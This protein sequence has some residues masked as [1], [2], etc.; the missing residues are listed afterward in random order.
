MKNAKSAAN[1]LRSLWVGVAMTIGIAV[2]E[3]ANPTQYDIAFS[4]GSGAP[5]GSFF[6]DVDVPS[7]SDFIVTWNG[8]TFNLT[9]SA[10]TPDRPS[11][12]SARKISSSETVT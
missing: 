3:L 9:G 10:N 5:T 8:L 12:A 2:S 11:S 6:Y 4:G 1:A 7:F